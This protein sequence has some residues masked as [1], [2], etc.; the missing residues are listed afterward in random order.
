MM[1]A[2]C[3][4]ETD[5]DTIEHFSSS[6]SSPAT[7][8]RDFGLKNDSSPGFLCIVVE[9]EEEEEEEGF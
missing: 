8:A 4:D 2:T 3:R 7:S 9:E 1:T 6:V 5:T